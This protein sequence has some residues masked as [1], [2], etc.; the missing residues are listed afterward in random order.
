MMFLFHKIA[1]NILN[2]FKTSRQPQRGP[3]ERGSSTTAS[4]SVE[5]GGI[6]PQA[7]QDLKGIKGSVSSPVIFFSFLCK[8][9]A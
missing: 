2:K 3:Q 8:H 9:S 6:K 5:N 7:G 1:G 4:A